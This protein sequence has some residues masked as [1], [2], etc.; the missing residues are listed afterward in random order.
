MRAVAKVFLGLFA[1]AL[2]AHAAPWEK[3]VGIDWTKPPASAK[4]SAW[5]PPKAKRMKLANGMALLVIERHDLPLYAMELVIPGAGS[6]ADGAGRAGLAELTADLLDEGAGGLSALELADQMERLGARIEPYADVDAATISVTGLVKTLDPTLELFAKVL[7][8]PAFGDQDVE[9][10]HGDRLTHVELRRDRPREIAALLLGATLYGRDASYGHPGS[11]YA[12]ELKKLGAADAKA[13][14]QANYHPASM[15]LVVAGDVDAKALKIKLDAS[16][17]AWKNASAKKPAA[18]VAKPAALGARLI[19]VDRP[20]AEQTDMRIGAAGIKKSHKHYYAAEVLSVAL[21]GSFT[22]RLTHRLREE[23]GYTYGIRTSFG[24]LREGGPFLISTGI[25]TP[26]TVDGVKEI[27]AITSDIATTDMGADE[28]RKVKQNIIRE[29]PQAFQ[30]NEGTV[31]AFAD[32]VIH[33]LPDAWYDSYAAKI[34]KVTAKQVRAAAEQL[35]DPKAT[36][37]VVVGDLATIRKGLEALG[38]GTV[39]EYDLDG[40]LSAAE[41]DRTKLER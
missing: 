25:F 4:E 35:L 1:L 18:T 24:M 19:L 11:G 14:Y 33:G 32:L 39:G 6:A 15:T 10:V 34:G 27:I 12:D 2:P 13:F 28:L 29:L 21:G 31:S 22:S 41:V 8:A 38:L 16:I 9:R 7:T 30:T 20:G 36:V 5:K 37:V 40:N 23:L 17:G 3:A 26:V